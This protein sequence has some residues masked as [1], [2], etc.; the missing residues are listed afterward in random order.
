MFALFHTAG[1]DEDATFLGVYAEELDA[2]LALDDLVE[3]GLNRDWRGNSAGGFVIVPCEPGK[4]IEVTLERRENTNA[5]PYCAYVTT[6][7]E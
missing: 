5:A 2:E 3:Q 4:P 6:R 7:T 1:C